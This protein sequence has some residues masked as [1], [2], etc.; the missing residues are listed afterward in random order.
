MLMEFKFDL[1]G[2][3]SS[4]VWFYPDF[5]PRYAKSTRLDVFSPQCG[6]GAERYILSSCLIL[7][8]PTG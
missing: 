7:A 5:L 2:I 1:T 3:T 8:P 4:Y 6:A